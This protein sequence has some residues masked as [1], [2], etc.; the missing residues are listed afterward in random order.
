MKTL[1]LSVLLLICGLITSQGTYEPTG[2]YPFGKPNPNA[3]KEIQDYAPMIGICDCNSQTRNQDQTWAEPVKM[4]WEFKYI[5]NGMAVQDQTIKEDGKHSGS[6]RQFIADSSRWFVHYYSSATPSTTLGTWEGNKK[7]DKI[8][9]YK[10]QNAPNGMEGF[11]KITFHEINEK[12]F[13]WLGEWTNK[14]KTISFPTWKIDCVKR[15]DTSTLS[16]EEQIRSLSAAFSASYI[17]QDYE[18]IA[19]SYTEDAKIFPNNTSIISGYE[20][21][22]KRWSGASGYVPI[23]HEIIPE[24]IIILGDTAHDYGYYKGKNKNNDG[25][26]LVYKGKYVVVWKK[27]N[28]QWKMY[29]DIWNRV[30]Q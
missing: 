14:D 27:I 8:I 23:E 29:L 12:G 1:V 20:A 24:E 6:I 16:D 28:N 25:S 2:A 7:G 17:K 30:K 18:A 15:K 21:I 22:K 3:P 4:T 19:R 5:M 26:E 13:K 9:L 11:F 10:K